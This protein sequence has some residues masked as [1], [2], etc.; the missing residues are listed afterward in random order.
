VKTFYLLGERRKRGAIGAFERFAAEIKA[1][2][3]DNA[4]LRYR[5]VFGGQ[6]EMHLRALPHADKAAQNAWLS[7]GTLPET[8]Q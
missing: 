3:E 8:K 7:S 6:F 2:D 1:S 4:R 5:S